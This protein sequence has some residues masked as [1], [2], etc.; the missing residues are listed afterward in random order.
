MCTFH[1]LYFN[2]VS[3]LEKDYDMFCSLYFD[4]G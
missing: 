1:I 2:Q 4:D 3:L